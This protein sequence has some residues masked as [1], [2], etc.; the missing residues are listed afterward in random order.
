MATTATAAESD[1]HHPRRSSW[2]SRA[3]GNAV[4]APTHASTIVMAER[5]DEA[6]LRV[7]GGPRW[8]SDV[9]NVALS[10]A[11][12]SDATPPEM[13]DWQSARSGRSA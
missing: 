13:P 6:A 10:I 3:S 1:R 5:W 9:T 4:G 2:A 7:G 12:L 8:G 11:G